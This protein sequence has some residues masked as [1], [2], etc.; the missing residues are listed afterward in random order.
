[1]MSK[2]IAFITDSHIEHQFPKDQGVDALGNWQ[3]VLE[4]VKAHKVDMIIIGGDI[5]ETKIFEYFFKS[6]DDLNMPYYSILGNHDKYEDVKPF[7]NNPLATNPNELFYTFDEDDFQYIFLDSSRGQV[8]QFQL[9][10]LEKTLNNSDLKP[11]VFI[12]HPLLKVNTRVDID[13]P[14]HNR[15]AVVEVLNKF[16]KNIPVICGHYHT[17]N[18]SINKNITQYVTPSAA[19]QILQNTDQVTLDISKFAYRLI[20]LE[21][22]N[23]HSRLKWFALV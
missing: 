11:L 7:L 22:G 23:F 8:S 19:F 20:E 12:H 2:T 6:L 1:M 18:Q 10:W 15:E 17:E 9:D 13:Y 5:G 21:N 4:S 16:D 14:L 3:M